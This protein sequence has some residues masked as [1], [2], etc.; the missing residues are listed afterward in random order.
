[1]LDTQILLRTLQI[2]VIGTVNVCK[3]SAAAM[4]KNEPMGEYKE[5]GVLINISSVAG[6][7]GQRG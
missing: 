3:F 6:I 5:R 2:N 7:E 1:V 4:I